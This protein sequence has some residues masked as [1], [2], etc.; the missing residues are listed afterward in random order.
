M[1]SFP[2]APPSSQT[3]FALQIRKTIQ[4]KLKVKRKKMKVKG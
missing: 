4:V 2:A 3:L 1:C